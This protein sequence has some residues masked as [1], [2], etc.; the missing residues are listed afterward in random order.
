MSLD[1]KLPTLN[2]Q[3][4]NHCPYHVSEDVTFVECLNHSE[5]GSDRRLSCVIDFMQPSANNSFTGAETQ[6]GKKE[7]SYSVTQC[8]PG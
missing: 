5:T 8:C 1:Y 4:K 2:K 3:R 7:A 6:T